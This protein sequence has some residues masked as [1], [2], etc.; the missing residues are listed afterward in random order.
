[1]SVIEAIT[2]ALCDPSLFTLT[3]LLK[4]N[5]LIDRSGP[6]ADRLKYEPHAWRICTQVGTHHTRHF[7]LQQAH[8]S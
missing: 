2:F 6:F 3:V 5:V 1:M 8:G 4:M 7:A